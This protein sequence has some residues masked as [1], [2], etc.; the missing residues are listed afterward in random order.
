M[1]D[2]GQLEVAN[3]II[4]KV[5]HFETLSMNSRLLGSGFTLPIQRNPLSVTF[6]HFAERE[7]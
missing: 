2:E 6:N 3:Q 5:G 1:H 4:A 7:L